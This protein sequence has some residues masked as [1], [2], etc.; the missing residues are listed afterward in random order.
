MKVVKG[1]GKGASPLFKVCGILLASAFVSASQA[2]ADGDGAKRIE[3]GRTLYGEQC[4]V[5]HGANLEGQPNWKK[6]GENGRLPAP[7]HDATGHT[8]HHRDKQLFEIT[9]KGT[10]AVVGGGYESDMAGFA[11][12]LTDDEIRTVLEF[13]E[14]TWPEPIRNRREKM[15]RR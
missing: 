6:L 12:V 1:S 3:L 8:W 5:C 10:A 11:E 15:R 14:S 4:A 13:I 7:P 9:K 2:S